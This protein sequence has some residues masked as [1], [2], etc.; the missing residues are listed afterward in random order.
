MS[1]KKTGPYQEVVSRCGLFLS[2]EL[3]WQT[4]HFSLWSCSSSTCSWHWAPSACLLS[5]PQAGL[6]GAL[7]PSLGV[8]VVLAQHLHTRSISVYRSVFK[9]L[10]PITGEQSGGGR[11]RQTQVRHDTS[12]GRL[13]GHVFKAQRIAENLLAYL[14]VTVSIYITICVYIYNLY[15]SIDYRDAA[16]R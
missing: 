2:K 7:V 3:H 4:I 6:A 8:F 15:Q 13:V 9:Q 14:R 16:N 1:S 12:S 5:A 11:L 10:T